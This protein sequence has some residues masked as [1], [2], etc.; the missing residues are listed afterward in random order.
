MRACDGEFICQALS[1]DNKGFV[2]F[3]NDTQYCENGQF[4]T[5]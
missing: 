3:V 5:S 4:Q 2:T 1:A